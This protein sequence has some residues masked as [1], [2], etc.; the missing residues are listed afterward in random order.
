MSGGTVNISDPVVQTDLGLSLPRRGL[1][2]SVTC[3]FPASKPVI[4]P[5]VDGQR[6]S[7]PSRLCC[8][9][10]R[11]PRGGGAKETQVWESEEDRQVAPARTT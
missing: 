10:H 11:Q 1:R 4:R 7:L 2:S 3:G 6:V 9:I 8:A 5:D